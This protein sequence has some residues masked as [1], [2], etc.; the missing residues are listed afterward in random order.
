MSAGTALVLHDY[1]R[2]T[3]SF[4]VRIALNLK[5]LPYET[6]GHDLRQ[7]GQRA[8]G[9]LALNRQGLVPALD[10][11]QMLVT[12]SGAIL[13]WLEERYPAPPLLP[14]DPD[15]RAIV[16]SMAMI[17]ACDIHPLNNLRVLRRLTGLGLDQ[18]ARDDWYRHWIAEGFGPLEALARPRA[19]RFLFGD[20]PTLADLCLVPQIF[21]ARRF[22]VP[23]DA[24]PTLVRADTEANGLEAFAAAHPDRVAPAKS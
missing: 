3:A 16:R 7:G 13:E 1:W 5:G 4:R 8:P 17:V 9:Y 18:E 14:D 12:Q 15:G 2:S 20:S 23:L 6:I 10:T 11:G 19:G 21:N 24:Y 22:D